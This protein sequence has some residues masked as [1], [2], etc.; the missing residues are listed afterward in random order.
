MESA[1]FWEE[2]NRWFSDIWV[3]LKGVKQSLSNSKLRDRSAA[4]P[5]ELA[6]R[7]I[8]MFS[9]KEDSVLD[10]FLGTDTTTLAAISSQRNSIGVE[11][12]STL[13]NHI[14]NKILTST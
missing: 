5:F 11:L 14:I 10:P 3:D 6:Y 1:Y 12:D 8:S 7:L 4:Y 13:Q 2:R 9:I